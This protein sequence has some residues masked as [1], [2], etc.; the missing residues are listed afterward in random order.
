M[1]VR[2]RAEGPAPVCRRAIL[3]TPSAIRA[4]WSASR[5][6]VIPRKGGF[7]AA[8]WGD[9]EDDPDYV[10]AARITVFDPPYRLLLT[11]FEYAA[12]SGPLPFQAD[13][14][15]EFSVAATPTGCLLTVYQTGFPSSANA[16]D[17][18]AACES[19]W[20]ATFEGIKHYLNAPEDA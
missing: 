12:R 13:L 6:I 15:T 3:H 4:W 16:D 19:G 17:Y 8:T 1:K 20:R 11:N 18:Y 7:W 9:R 10:V 5:S 2:A 14:S